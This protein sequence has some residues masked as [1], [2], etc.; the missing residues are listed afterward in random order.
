MEN[1]KS[2]SKKS[3]KNNLKPK[4]NLDDNDDPEAPLLS[5]V[6]RVKAT[7]LA[8]TPVT[9]AG[10]IVDMQGT[11]N[12]DTPEKG[13]DDKNET[14]KHDGKDFETL[15]TNNNKEIE[16]SESKS[17]LENKESHTESQIETSDQSS[18]KTSSPTTDSSK[19]TLPVTPGKIYQL[20]R[21]L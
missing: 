9:P 4:S 16:N 18:V 1:T 6:E 20:Y 19:Q 21:K 17:N 8:T 5:P 15:E 3:K 2:K 14:S 11:L 10:Y 13:D 12:Q 7:H